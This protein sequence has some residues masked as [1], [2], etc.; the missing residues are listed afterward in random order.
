MTPELA[1]LWT[2]HE[3]D[4]RLIAV[5]E[6]LARI[7]AERRALDAR[8]VAERGR[9]ERHQKQLTELRLRRSQREKDAAALQIEERRFAQQQGL[10]KTNAEFQ[11]LTH[12]IEGARAR[13]SDVE[14]E[15]LLLMD[16]EQGLERARPGLDRELAEVESEVA[17]KLATLDD[18]ERAARAEETEL[19]ARRAAEL[20]ALPP[21]TRARYERVRESK[22]GR[23]VVAIAK[24]ACGGC[25]RGLAPQALQESRKRDRVLHCD[26]CGRMMM[27][28]P[29]AE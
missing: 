4:E 26:G 18:E 28:P 12:E 19:E 6:G 21:A 24:G 13:R 17:A 20:P 11:A 9:L 16:E 23:A 25:F 14:T 1:T 2:L 22:G 15:V 8:R 3:L 29:D 5:R 10:V 7:P 27:L